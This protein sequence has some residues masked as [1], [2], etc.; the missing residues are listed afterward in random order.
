MNFA[1]AGT[2]WLALCTS[3]WSGIAMAEATIAE[4]VD[5]TPFE[6]A[7]AGLNSQGH[8]LLKTADKTRS[9]PFDDLLS[10]GT[11]RE[12][13]G[14]VLLLAGGDLLGIDE[15][16]MS[17]EQLT[18]HSATFGPVALPRGAVTA[19]ILNPPADRQQHDRLLYSLAEATAES[20]IL[21]LTNGDELTGRVVAVTKEHLTL[22]G[23][24][25]KVDVPVG[26]VAAVVFA[27][28]A[29]KL[30]DDSKSNAVVGF[31]DGSRLHVRTAAIDGQKAEFTTS[32][33]LDISSVPED[34]AALMPISSKVAYLSQRKSAGY[35]HVP[36]FET[37]WPYQTDK[38]VIGTALR[39][40]GRLYLKGIGVHS[41]SGLTYQLDGEFRR[42]EAELAIDDSADGRGSVIFKVYT[43]DGSGRWQPKYTSPVIRGGMTPTPISVDLQGAKRLSLLVEFA[44]RGDELDRANWLRARLVK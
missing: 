17:G 11:W 16:E 27:S 1:T 43:D 13:S 35:N 30:A 9:I 6:A 4:P 12:S 39:S 3:V 2:L 31:V 38:S 29:R 36:F 21:R 26:T 14:A 5:G 15:L 42:F 20:D 34:V 7:L 32:A 18:A 24:I 22:E 44:D 10:W 8:V 28:S 37:T 19:A 25:G 40:D 33:G 41:A 23:S